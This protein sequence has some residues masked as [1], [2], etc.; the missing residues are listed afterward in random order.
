MTK[1]KILFLEDDLGYRESVGDYL[2][3]ADFTVETC[4]NGEEF[5]N[6]IFHNVYDLYIIDINVPKVNGFEIMKSLKEYNDSTMKLVISSWQRYLHQSFKN[7]CDDFINKNTD[8]DEIILRIQALIKRTY[9]TYT[10]YINLDANTRYD[11]FHKQL[12]HNGF[13]VELENKTLLV[14]DY[15]IKNRGR[16]I[17]KEDLEKNIYSCCSDC[18]ANVLRYHICNLRK[19]I[20]NDIIES[21]YKLGYMLKPQI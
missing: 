10:N 2:K 19:A 5:L 14:L 17:T 9:H 7:G 16:F 8:I 20:G 12:F 11:F 3:Q 13:A 1:I 6:K 15:L 4:S 21:K 18:K